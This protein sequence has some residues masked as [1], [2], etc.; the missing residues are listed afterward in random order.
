MGVSALNSLSQFLRD[1]PGMSTAPC[2]DTG[3]CLRGKFWFKASVS[4]GDE[5][6]DSYKL[7]IVVSDKFPQ[8]LPKVKETG[9]KIP[10]DGNFHVNPDGTLC[11]GSPLR[12]LR[13]VHSSPSL[14]GFADK[15]L[16]PYLYAVSYKLMHG[17][18]FVFGELAHGDQGIVDD[19]SVM[20][21]LKEKHQ[22][23]R[24]IQLLGI[25]K[26]IANKKLCP[27]GCG[28]RLGACPFHH[29]LNEFRKMAPVSWFKAH[30][31]N[32]WNRI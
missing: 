21:G 20:L 32:D 8:A 2:S 4:S 31:L 7:E 13:K 27:C 15:C 3:V 24:A 30:A 6:D 29:K 1:Y 5:I 14:T 23:Q 22:I 11:L 28:K 12:L 26:R 19:Y 9:G 25:K 10:R 17:G 16:V 18:D